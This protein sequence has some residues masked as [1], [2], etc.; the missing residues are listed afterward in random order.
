MNTAQISRRRR[1]RQ[2]HFHSFGSNRETEAASGYFRILQDSEQRQGLLIGHKTE[3]AGRINLNGMVYLNFRG[4]GPPSPADFKGAPIMSEI[5]QK[6][7]EAGG[8]EIDL[9]TFPLTPVGGMSLILYYS[10]GE[11]RR[12][13]LLNF[14]EG[15]RRKVTMKAVGGDYALY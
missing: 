7:N 10:L 6:G 12:V 4:R 15:V 2:E 14:A 13:Y 8:E 3:K 9:Y 1:K 11:L 5:R